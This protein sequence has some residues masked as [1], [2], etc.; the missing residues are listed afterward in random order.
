MTYNIFKIFSTDDSA[1]GFV[2]V[3]D[4]IRSNLGES[5]LDDIFTLKNIV[6]N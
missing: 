6:K 4:T 1:G 2:V 5:R 3:D